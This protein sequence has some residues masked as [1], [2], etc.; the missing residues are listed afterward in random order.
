MLSLYCL[1]FHRLTLPKGVYSFR[2]FLSPMRIPNLTMH[3]FIL[4]TPF[5]VCS[6]MYAYL[7][8]LDLNAYTWYTH[9]V[10]NCNSQAKCI[11]AWANNKRI[12]HNEYMHHQIWYTHWGQ[13]V[14]QWVYAFWK[15]KPVNGTFKISNIHKRFTYTAESEHDWEAAQRF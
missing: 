14:P 3:I 2:Y 6:C 1:P 5:V 7:L 4:P 12:W 13:E 10:S 11:Y 9:W 15:C 8:Q